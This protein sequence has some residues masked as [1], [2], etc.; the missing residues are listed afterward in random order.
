MKKVFQQSETANI[1]MKTFLAA[2]LFVLLNSGSV[3]AQPTYR[4][5]TGYED[6]IRIV[7]LWNTPSGYCMNNIASAAV[8]HE[9]RDTILRSINFINP[10]A[11]SHIKAS[12]IIVLQ[13]A[14][15]SDG[16][17]N[18]GGATLYWSATWDTIK[19]HCNAQW[20]GKLPHVIVHSNAG[21]GGFN[22]TA[23]NTVMDSA[24]AHYIG[25]VEVG[26]DAAWSNN[27]G[28][29][30]NS[31][32]TPINVFGLTGVNNMP[33]P[34]ND[35]T[36]LNNATSDSLWVGLNPIADSMVKTTLFPH[37][38]GITKNAATINNSNR[39]FFKPYNGTGSVD[40]YRCQ[41]DADKY[42]ILAGY[43]A[44]LHMLGYQQGW[45]NGALVQTPTIVNGVDTNECDVVVALQDTVKRHTTQNPGDNDLVRRCVLL[46][47]EPEFLKNG[48]ASQQMVYDAIMYASLA[49]QLMPVSQISITS[50]PSV[51]TI[52]AGDSITFNVHVKDDTGGYYP[53][54]DNLVRWSMRSTGLYSGSHLA[55]VTGGTNTFYAIEAYQ[56]YI[57][58]AQFQQNATSTIV[59]AYDTVKVVPGHT[60]HLTLEASPDST[61]SIT[62]DRRMV[63]TTFIST[64]GIGAVHNTYAVLRDAYGNWVRH[65]QVPLT[66]GSRA[67]AIATGTP[68]ANTT[69]GE[70]AITRKTL[71]TAST[72]IYATQIDTERFQSQAGC[73]FYADSAIIPVFDSV[74]VF[75][76]NVSY[77]KINIV[78]RDSARDSISS[79]TMRI[80]MDTVLTAYGLRSDG[81]GIWDSIQVTWGSTPGLQYRNNPPSGSFNWD[82]RP[83]SVGTGKIWINYV[84]GT[85]NLHDTITVTYTNP[86]PKTM[87]LY[88]AAGQPSTMTAYGPTA[89]VTAGTPFPLDAK[90]FGQNNKGAAVWLS[91]YERANAPISWTI[92]DTSVGKLDATTGY[93]VHFTGHKAYSTVTISASFD[94]N[95]TITASIVI[96]VNPGPATKLDIEPDYSA[97]TAYPNSPHR[98]GSVT[99]SSTG[100][101][102]SVFAV[103]RDQYGNFVSFST[104]P[105]WLS[106]DATKA[107][108]LLGSRTYGEGVITRATATGQVIVLGTDSA[109]AALFD[110]VQ[111]V[112][113]NI[114]YTALRIVVRNNVDITQLNMTIDND[115]ML[116]VLGQR[117]D[118][119][120]W[121]AV[122]A[123]WSITP[124]LRTDFSAPGA[125]SSW[126]FM[127]SDTGTAW[128]KVTLAGATADSVLAHFS[129]G[130]P[131]NMALYPLDGAP[132]GTT[133][134]KYSDPTGQFAQT[135]I[136]TAG[137]PFQVEAKVFDKAANWLGNFD[138]ASSPVTWTLVALDTAT[139]NR[140][141]FTPNIG[142]KTIFTP[143]EAFDSVYIIGTF[144][145]NGVTA[146]DTVKVKV[147]AGVAAKLVIKASPD[148]SKYLNDSTHLGVANLGS[149]F[150]HDS[151]YAVLFDAK[152]NFV[153]HVTLANPWT[154]RN[155]AWLSVAPGRT[156]IGE[157]INTRQTSQ[158][159]YVYIVAAQGTMA[160]SVYVHV[161]GPSYS[162]I[163]ITAHNS[164][165]DSITKLV[166]RTDSP[167]TTIYAFGLRADGSGIWDNIGVTW[168]EKAG[169]PTSTSPVNGSATWTFHPVNI[170]DSTNFIYI[171]YGSYRDSIG[172]TFTYGIPSSISLWNKTGAP[173][174]T[175]M[176]KYSHTQMT[177]TAGTALPVFAKLFSSNGQFLPGFESP[178]APQF[179]WST[180]NA[181]MGTLSSNSGSSTSFTG[182]TAGVSGTIYCTYTGPTANGKPLQDSIVITVFHGP[183]NKLV[184]GADTANSRTNLYTNVGSVSILGTTT[185]ISVYAVLQ[186][187]FNNYVGFSNPTT[188]SSHDI[189]QATV[190][191]G[192][193]PAIGQGTITRQADQGQTY[194]VAKDAGTGFVDTVQ[195]ILSKITYNALRIVVR[196]STKIPSLNMT[197]EDDTTLRVQ[198]Q[199]SDN[200]VWEYVPAAWS[201]RSVTGNLANATT[202]PAP[203]SA[204]SWLVVPKDTATG[205][206]KVTLGTAKPDSLPVVFTIGIARSIKLYPLAG[207]PLTMTAYPN[208]TIPNVDTAGHALQVVAKI[209]DKNGDWLNSYETATAPITWTMSEL[210]GN[211]DVPTGSYTPFTG[212]KTAFSPVRADNQVYL[213]GT[214]SENGNTF[215][216]TILVLVKAGS[217]YR[218]TLEASYDKNVNPHGIGFYRD[219]LVPIAGNAT[220]GLIYAIIRDTLGNYIG[221][222]AHT[223]WVSR[224]SSVVTAYDGDI[225]H[226][227]G[228]I[229]R[230]GSAVKNTAIVAAY[231]NDYTLNGSPLKDSTHAQLQAY[232]YL[233]LRITN[234]NGT[235]NDTI[236]A[237]SMNT[238]QD[239][240]LKVIGQRSDNGQWEAVSAAWYSS[241]GLHITPVAPGN[242]QAWTFSP[243]T[244]GTGYIRVTVGNDTN[245]TKPA[246]IA[247]NFSVGPPTNTTITIITPADSIKAGDTV[248]AVVSIK[249][250]DGQV[251]GS[252]CDSVNYY[253]PVTSDSNATVIVKNDT[254][255]MGYGKK[256]E[257]CFTNGL[258]TIKMVFYKDTTEKV[259]VTLDT[260]PAAPATTNPFTVKPGDLTR[261][262]IVD[263]SG[264][265]ITTL[266]LANGGSKVLQAI[267][268]DAYGNIRGPELGNWTDTGSIAPI[269]NGTGTSSI[270]YQ[271]GTVVYDESGTIRVVAIG[272]T[273]ALVS[274]SVAVNATGQFVTL[275][276]SATQDTNGNGLLDGVVLK[277][278]KKFTMTDSISNSLVV[279][280]MYKGT[281][282][283]LPV[284]SITSQSGNSY[285]SVFVVHLQETT[286]GATDYVGQTGWTPT[287]TIAGFPQDGNSKITQTVTDNAGPVIMTVLNTQSSTSSHAADVVT[288]T[289]SEPIG[290]NGDAFDKAHYSPSQFL[291]AWKDSLLPSGKDTLVQDLSVLAG[292]TISSYTSSSNNITSIS[293]QMTNGQNLNSLEYLSL[294]GGNAQIISD[295]TSQTNAPD[296]VNIKRQ[297]NTAGGPTAVINILPNPTSATTAHVPAGSFSVV[298]AP[299]APNWITNEKKG[300]DLQFN[301]PFS[302]ANIDTAG[303]YSPSD[304]F[305]IYAKIYDIIGNVVQSN[306][307]QVSINP[308]GSSSFSYNIYWNGYNEKGMAVASGVYKVLVVLKITNPSTSA[309]HYIKLVNTI[310]ITYR[311]P[312]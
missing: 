122:P 168:G 238:N 252:Y 257:E 141:L 171:A 24:L 273:G 192:T 27:I 272:K 247:V 290:S 102:A 186:D 21:W 42:K 47:I 48:P 297:V 223:T 308:N 77:Q 69:I 221:T 239:T 181:N 306:E 241:T 13:N 160:D 206:V 105:V 142:Y 120:A 101:Q 176:I 147:V 158:D 259:Q 212:Y 218:L 107:T 128:I 113:S 244:P 29:W 115:T 197:I 217:P 30:A 54:Y 126:R 199:R 39:L 95:K 269:N 106:R 16:F 18:G 169:L 9:T 55:V 303:S 214:Y 19:A 112:L 58:T 235:I 154:S 3:L 68:T 211:T 278:S 220:Y 138:N 98:A 258:D 15:Y 52:G 2:I 82:V 299:A 94:S 96:S 59:Y 136:V 248:L 249:N 92:S 143:T 262:A 261:I 87:A 191:I 265:D 185:Q 203:S 293:F 301:I 133:N 62:G 196:D 114:S 280:V 189:A 50:C 91:A 67:A 175:T 60:T 103:L 194:V 283:T 130:N 76:N 132:N 276:S 14:A 309:V 188:W 134:A 111:V 310:G 17:N 180:S 5:D 151:L 184:I 227:Q 229:L 57:I 88:P 230:N 288:V 22:G 298:N 215:S 139:G 70:G 270:L 11:A 12:N 182:Y 72:Y 145:Q 63:S 75:L 117:S 110:S 49:W 85:T 224:D 38:N 73:G 1:L 97:P 228:V 179:T 205:Y 116:Q 127:P 150:L 231:S 157:G 129:V 61:V 282:Y 281:T 64:D 149:T 219:T 204:Q 268:Y 144:S 51:S 137:Q 294:L 100:T 190:A 193:Y 312:K 243:D 178:N 198:G 36:Q 8:G 35:A 79:L 209:F 161:S 45:H 279:T 202:I 123:A 187:Q 131:N 286:S 225:S 222:S 40:Q 236:S 287:V 56:T 32:G 251:P 210:A 155:P 173:D 302:T 260:V 109:N 90:I 7:V 78:V 118:N 20:A 246:T 140:T 156:A 305:Y 37:L 31:T 277:F 292:L 121:E 274:D 10:Q 23:L 166:M 89:P 33:P 41:A 250:N 162:K 284:S 263:G 311:I 253:D 86:L 201:V 232:Y 233:G 307:G 177:V 304:Q 74:Q 80:D 159:V 4:V 81:S 44:K 275:V 183:A 170:A 53:Q 83:D 296:I 242:A 152:G 65:A 165:A 254:T 237:L 213:I 207:N 125:A 43:A 271:A 164:F 148:S 200:N 66:W 108:V 240:T 300:T 146:I 124:V 174:T 245:V 295:L 226:G 172:V 93:L 195:V 135:Y 28:N 99:I 84:A 46:S 163:N 71:T 234:V 291:V 267:G 34:M 25:I 153:S 6:S 264:N 26:D 255:T 266:N 119:S 289:F 208:P 167:D 216:D 104:P 256:I 285:D